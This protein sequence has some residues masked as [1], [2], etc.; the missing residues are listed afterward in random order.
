M[1][2][3]RSCY[4]LYSHCGKP[5][6]YREYAVLYRLLTNMSHGRG[7]PSTTG[8]GPSAKSS[9]GSVAK[10][11]SKAGAAAAAAVAAKTAAKKSSPA[12]SASAV[13]YPIALKNAME[14]YILKV[15]DT[16][17]KQLAAKVALGTL[18]GAAGA[19]IGVKIYRKV[20]DSTST[21]IPTVTTPEAQAAIKFHGEKKALTPDTKRFRFEL[22]SHMHVSGVP[23]G[24]F[25]MMT[26]TINGKRETRCYTPISD[27]N[28]RGFVD[29]AIK[30]YPPNAANPNGGVVSQFIDKLQKGDEVSIS[31]PYGLLSY[32]KNGIFMIKANE[33]AAPESKEIRRIGMLAAGSGVTAMIPILRAMLKE[34]LEAPKCSLVYSNL[35]DQDII[36]K[37]ELNY[38]ASKYRKRF[39]LWYLVDKPTNPS[40]WKYG[41][42]QM[43]EEWLKD[44]MPKAESG[45]LILICGPKEMA[46][47]CKKMLSGLNYTNDMIYVFS[48]P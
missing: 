12:S 25:I 41:I 2:M 28:E 10:T 29:F 39:K 9:V 34:S 17:E 4:S 47:N 33:K 32:D 11:A 43:S 20:R 45:V 7:A 14:E 18:V 19:V 16:P 13:P 5:R 38:M 6:L 37:S 35:T 27:P 48:A 1:I 23:V 30:V 22:P 15:L 31:G 36:L 46:D 8:S 42:G 24:N 21:T 40:R 3:D 26:V 44:W